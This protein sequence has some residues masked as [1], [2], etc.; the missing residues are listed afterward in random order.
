MVTM[1]C[2]ETAERMERVLQLIDFIPQEHIDQLNHA[3]GGMI[4]LAQLEKIG[5]TIP[6][7]AIHYAT[8]PYCPGSGQFRTAC[9]KIEYYSWTTR[10]RSKVTCKNCLS[11]H[12]FK[13]N[14]HRFGKRGME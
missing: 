11:S 4:Y 12:M 3:M 8:A 6:K 1:R 7:P 2:R 13:L 10:D 5:K 9:D 14:D